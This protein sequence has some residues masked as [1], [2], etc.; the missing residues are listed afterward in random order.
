MTRR[1]TR[2]RVLLVLGALLAC[3]LL[4]ALL[5]EPGR[6]E[7]PLD[8]EAAGP[9]GAKALAQV[10]SD[11][12]VEVEVVRT[13]ED[14]SE[15]RLEEDTTVVVTGTPMLTLDHASR[16]P[17]LSRDARRLVLLDLPEP[18]LEQTDLPV[19]SLPGVETGT[20]PAECEN[21][22]SMTEAG[23]VR[24]GDE[25][26]APSVLYTASEGAST[27]SCFPVEGASAR[28][29][30]LAVVPAGAERP[31]SVLLA[32]ASTLSNREITT[33]DHAGVA[34]RLLGATD[35]VV[36]YAPDVS[37]VAAD[38]EAVSLPAWI[39][40]G[41]TLLGVVFVL[42]ALQQGRRLGPLTPE[43][44]P[45]VVRSAETTRS[46][47]ALYRRSR[48]RDRAARVL[49]SST[50]HRLRTRLGIPAHAPPERVVPAV[51]AAAGLPPEDVGH[52]LF[53]PAPSD[54]AGL[55][56]LS[57]QLSTL[58]EGVRTRE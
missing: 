49:R 53:G 15:A 1:L 50:V 26:V 16:L 28:G 57:R 5:V 32:G 47:A 41:L 6:S 18:A 23:I 25:I 39:A 40:P 21:T 55:V 14:L 22:E 19:T 24:P 36:W 17:T 43:P 4:A 56:R 52:R 29:S 31:E 2:T 46:R 3:G 30:A 12:G 27:G 7:E 38:E 34:T 45:V 51:A 35:R 8:P 13:L 42:F 11:R 33:A 44:L 58:E 54:D 37:D 9:A 10:L 48:D 20:H